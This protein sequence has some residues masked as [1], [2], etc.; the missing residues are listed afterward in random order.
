MKCILTIVL[1]FFANILMSQESYMTW[2]NGYIH[3]KGIYHF[4]E[5]GERTKIQSNPEFYQVEINDTFFFRNESKDTLFIKRVNTYD[6]SLFYVTKVTPPKKIGYIVFRQKVNGNYLNLFKH[7]KYS[8]NII[9][10]FS[11]WIYVNID[12]ILI[13]NTF[14][15]KEIIGNQIKYTRKIDSTKQLTLYASNKDEPIS[16]G[17]ES[18]YDHQ[19]LLKWTYWENGT[20]IG[21]TVHLKK[22]SVLMQAYAIGKWKL[23]NCAVLKN[24][25]WE[26]AKSYSN[27]YY[28]EL[29]YDEHCDSFKLYNDSEYVQLPIIYQTFQEVRHYQYLN[30]MKYNAD[31]YAT[32]FNV[33]P[34]DY[35]DLNF[36]LILKDTSK[37]KEIL[38]ALR[39][40]YD[41]VVFDHYVNGNLIC[42]LPD[43][44]SKE[45]Q[46]QLITDVANEV[47]VVYATQLFSEKGQ[48]SFFYGHF[49]AQKLYVN[50]DVKAICKANHFSIE[51]A[52]CNAYYSLY[53]YDGKV[54][55]RSFLLHFG[56]LMQSL[57]ESNKIPEK[58]QQLHPEISWD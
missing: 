36:V 39:W 35:F 58:Y 50:D 48:I 57:R 1:V 12:Y 31:H 16:M 27:G 10:N 23:L 4:K 54:L 25:K 52:N 20:F 28:Y 33:Y 2:L 24:N 42:K 3:S 44:I 56:Q 29:Y 53:T 21:D 43:N 37:N 17:E 22:I 7:E 41:G 40:H 11:P 19:R 38:N 49:T 5:K 15:K 30:L 55:D 9:T 47:G 6:T 26:K 45:R 18:M 8:I 14:V 51:D 34:I 32:Q 46:K 13:N